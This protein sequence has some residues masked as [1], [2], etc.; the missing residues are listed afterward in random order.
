MELAASEWAFGWS[1]LVAIATLLLAS[2][3]ATLAYFTR[4][5]V[6]SAAEQIGLAREELQILE[7]QTKAS[8]THH[9]ASPYPCVYP[10][11]NT[12][13]LLASHCIHHE[14]PIRNGMMSSRTSRS[15]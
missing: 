8:I 3:T 6:E 4:G 5:S 7:R 9:E 14:I 13:W 11:T 12:E 2:A 1:A 15:C 10:S